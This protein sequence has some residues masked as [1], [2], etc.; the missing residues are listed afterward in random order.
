MV[1]LLRLG[2]L[3]GW[4]LGLLADVRTPGVAT[5]ASAAAT[6]TYT[7]A[8]LPDIAND[9]AFVKANMSRLE[10][11]SSDPFAS[12]TTSILLVAVSQMSMSRLKVLTLLA[13]KTAW[14]TQ[15]NAAG[16]G[17]CSPSIGTQADWLIHTEYKQKQR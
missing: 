4:E 7:I 17:E 1:I 16:P 5:S 12:K 8:V 15:N 6:V 2:L 10:S 9:R 3:Q 13:D 14:F 11:E